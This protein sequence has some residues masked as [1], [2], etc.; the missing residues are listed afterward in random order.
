MAITDRR[1]KLL[2]FPEENVSDL[3]AALIVKTAR[4]RRVRLG[5]FCFH[6]LRFFEIPRVLVHLDHVARPGENA[7]HGIV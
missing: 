5:D 3:R 7:N 6:A 1:L 2:T 4:L